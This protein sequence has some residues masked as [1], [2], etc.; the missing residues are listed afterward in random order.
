MMAPLRFG[1][2]ATPEE[3]LECR[4]EA[5]LMDRGNLLKKLQKGALLH[6]ALAPAYTHD[7]LEPALQPQRLQPQGQLQG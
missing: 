6:H 1:K 3:L 7:E 5:V 2:C 4:P